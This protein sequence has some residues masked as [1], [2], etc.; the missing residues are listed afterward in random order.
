MMNYLF[1]WISGGLFI[2]FDLTGFIIKTFCIKEQPESEKS[3]RVRKWGWVLGVVIGICAN[4]FPRQPSE[5]IKIFGLPVPV[6]YWVLENGKWLDYVSSFVIPTMVLNCIL[7]AYVP[8]AAISIYLFI[9]ARYGTKS[10]LDF[11]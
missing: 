2:T 4:Y 5:T 3:K 11:A 10:K 8:Q 1:Y 7:I 6:A 9:K